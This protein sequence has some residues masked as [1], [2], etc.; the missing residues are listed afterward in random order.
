LSEPVQILRGERECRFCGL[1]QCLP[2]LDRRQTACCA[3]CNATLRRG[4]GGT[5]TPALAC[6]VGALFLF[7][8]ALTL[9]F[10]NVEAAGKTL[11]ATILTGPT[12]LDRRGMWEISA[13]VVFTLVAMPAVQFLLLTVVLLGLR[14]PT[15]PR[16][17]AR[18]FGWLE[19]VRPWS[20]IEVFLLGVFVAYTRLQAIATV[21]VGPAIFALGGMVLCLVAA[22]ATLDHDEVWHAL[23]ARGLL[24]LRAPP[25][26]GR[27]IGCD[28]CG[29]V[30][31]APSLWPCPRCGR[32]LRQRKRQSIARSWALLA[33]AICLYL[34]ANLYPIITVIRFGQGAPS[35]IWQ[36]V[37][38]LIDA[39]MWP[40]AAIVFL[41]SITVPLLKL[42][43]MTGMLLMTHERSARWLPQRTALYRLVDA[44]GRWSMIDV[45]MLT[46][47]VALV[48]L[49]FI[50]TVLPGLGAVAFAAVVVL[51]M[52]AAA[53]F[54]P[55]LMWDA[56]GV[57]HVI[58]APD[59]LPHAELAG[60]PA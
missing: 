52:L 60:S 36:G 2:A 7:L 53:A 22:D 8:L 15:P 29:L 20:M 9:P 55:R 59:D 24:H 11:H 47:L 12:M 57:D 56:A 4:A 3:R 41:A 42:I 17:L 48:R 34:P 27:R 14:L 39:Q 54:D 58:P 37:I 18:L 6:S 44:V 28:C 46:T 13:V 26:G 32:R 10:M 51:S 16:G 49:G 45:F 1:F 19:R 43:S 31:C 30:L 35:T 5:L 21:Q 50:A 38:E 23:E 33:A 40:L 25:P